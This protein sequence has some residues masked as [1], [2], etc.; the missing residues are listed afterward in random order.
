M[1]LFPNSTEKISNR[2]L[3]SPSLSILIAV[4]NTNCGLY[5]LTLREAKTHMAFW[6]SKGKSKYCNRKEDSEQM[7]ITDVLGLKRHSLW[8]VDIQCPHVGTTS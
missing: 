6:F 3:I 4:V 2:D 7:F 1:T 8:I 5:K